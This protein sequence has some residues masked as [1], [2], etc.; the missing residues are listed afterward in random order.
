MSRASEPPFVHP[1]AIVADTARIG[2]GTRIWAFAQVREGALLG[3]ECN[4]GSGA[5]VGAGVVVG[6]RCKIENYASLFEG[7]TIE[8]GVFVG[9]HV[10][11]TND[12]VPR[13]MNPDGTL[14]TASDWEITGSTVRKG[15]S[16]GAGSIVL[17]GCEI[18]RH[19]MVGAGAVVTADVPAHALVVGTPARVVGWI[20]VCGRSRTEAFTPDD[21]GVQRCSH[22]R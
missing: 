9:P 5:Y 15:A 4:V 17:P 2:T 16:L 19:A 18:G 20:C 12:R 7:S 6:D 14:Q 13:A 11:F 21:D 22:C 1:S 10:V 3:Q 8:A